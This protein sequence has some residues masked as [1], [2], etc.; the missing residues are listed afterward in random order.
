M[1]FF[2]IIIGLPLIVMLLVFAFVNNNMVELS[3]WPADLEITISQSVLIVFLYVL[4]YLAG[5]FFTW[6][7]YSPIR[8][9]LRAQR[10]ENRKM[11]KEQEKLN[12]EVEDLKGN[13]DVLKAS[14][15]PE[16]KRSFASWF[17]NIF[18]SGSSPDQGE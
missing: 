15:P 2:K 10:K 11:S 7:S 18:K 6:V 4:G 17:K 5:W 14:T 1:F 16:P 12:K 9:L 8:R 13:I 3:L